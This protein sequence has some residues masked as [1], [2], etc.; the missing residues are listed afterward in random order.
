MTLLTIGLVYLGL[1][2]LLAAISAAETAIGMSRELGGKVLAA[3][4][5]AVRRELQSISANP[6][7][8]LHRALLLSAMLNLALAASALFLA[9][10]PLRELGWQPWA[11]AASL[12][13]LAVLIGDVAPKFFAARSPS[14]ILLAAT[15]M[16]KP[17]RFLLDPPLAVV[18]RASEQIVRLVVP[19]RVK[20][21]QPI[22]QEELETL[23]EIR[24]EQG[25]L[26]EAEAA[27]I[28]E[29]IS[30][31]HLTVRDC[32][33]PRV[34][35][36][37]L[38]AADAK[39]AG[40]AVLE[41]AE[42]RFVLVHG[43]TPDAVHGVIDSQAWKLAGRPDVL[44]QVRPP[45]FVPETLSALDAVDKH[46]G[47]FSRC[48]LVVDEYGG[49]EG[50]LT[51]DEIADWLLSDAAPWQGE[52]AE[53]RDLGDGRLLL[54]GG[55][56]LDDIERELGIEIASEGIDTIGGFVFTQLGHVPKPGERISIPGADIKVRRVSRSRV[57]QVEMR[58][59]REEAAAGGEEEPS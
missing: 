29:I 59:H 1:L 24:E 27:I 39:P 15:K 23:I 8:H 10:G 35:L 52:E 51:L 34:S 20:M 4:S 55:T 36:A 57:Q 25:A 44:S 9:T 18:E 31:A 3:Q 17:A 22:T 21:R 42:T 58:P 7:P 13:G 41:K 33:I 43:D 49:L 14:R 2:L 48:V 47:D 19:K 38:P 32:M 50:M 12:F 6:F 40:E 37:M 11:S 30:M 26:E 28:R 56:R 45:V 16:L 54:D 46:L 5:P 53:I